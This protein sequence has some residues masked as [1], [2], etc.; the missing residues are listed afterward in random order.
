M[1]TALAIAGVTHVLRDR[2]N[3]GMVNNN[4]AGVLGSTVTVS[5]AMPDRVVASDSTEQSQLNVFLC[6]ASPNTGWSPMGLPTHSPDGRARLS[7]APLAL[8]LH[9]VISAYSGSD[10]H[11]E[12]LLGHAMQLMHEF[13]VIT[14]EMI[15]TSLAP[16][17]SDLSDL[18]PTLRALA[19]T[20]LA[21]QYEQL[22]ITPRYMD[23]DEI[24]K[25]WTATQASY[26]PSAA[27]VI[28]VVLIQ[29]ERPAR[30]A[31]P[32]L[33]RG[34]PDPATGRDRGVVV[35]PDLVPPLPTIEQVVFANEEPSAR[36][37]QVV[38]L[39]GHH[40]NGANRAG[41]L[42]NEMFQI[43]ETIAAS[44]PD[45]ADRLEFTIPAARA[46]DFP[47]GVYE[48]R[49][50]VTP[51]GSPNQ[52]ETN[53]LSVLLAPDITNLPQTI[54]RDG[55]GDLAVTLTFTPEARP[56]QRV[57][58]HIGQREATITA[59]APPAAT[60]DAALEDADAGTVPVILSIDGIDSNIIDRTSSPPV[61]ATREVTIT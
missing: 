45:V 32:V 30:Q 42:M 43:D 18:P 29:N 46:A 23:I 37:G 34:E 5:V 4:V 16:P 1:S 54:A 11:A 27:Y 3:D 10:L 12:I 44:G 50:L 51:P 21:D 22:R 48:V 7:N 33:T 9:Y 58:V 20:G 2:L 36:L 28:S 55:N 25:L 59:I 53:V 38:A 15:R 24:S 57:Q 8:D 39:T 17:N 13:P 6:N 19:E 41:R 35:T 14:R 31:L 40:L 26:R 49:G 56:G 61:F 60:L 47:A 52:R